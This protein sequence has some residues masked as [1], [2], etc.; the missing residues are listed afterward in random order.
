M[1]KKTSAEKLKK[2]VTKRSKTEQKIKKL[3][4]KKTVPLRKIRTK[5]QEAKYK[6]TQ[7]K[8][9]ANPTAQANR[10]NAKPS[11]AAEAANRLAK[12][13]MKDKMSKME[14]DFIAKRKKTPRGEMTEYQRRMLERR[15]LN[16]TKPRLKQVKRT[17]R[18]TR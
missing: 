18:R 16:K 8:I 13:R 14:E 5:I 11:K 6:K 15:K 3:K 2:L 1:A 4:T 17:I 9:N 12:R 10:K 7:K